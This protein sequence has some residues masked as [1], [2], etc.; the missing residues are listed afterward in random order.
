LVY[1]KIIKGNIGKILPY[2]ILRQK[3]IEKMNKKV[4]IIYLSYLKWDI[5]IRKQIVTLKKEGYDIAKVGIIDSVSVI[6]GVDSLP[7]SFSWSRMLSLLEM[8]CKGLQLVV[9]RIFECVYERIYRN[10]YFEQI[11][12]VLSDKKFDLYI[13]NDLNSLPPAIELKK[14]NGGKVL[15]DAHE[16]SPL[17]FANRWYWNFLIFPYRDYLCKKYLPQADY[18]ITVCDSLADKYHKEYGVKSEVIR[19]IP[20]YC[21][22]DFKKTNPS[23]IRMVHHGVTS[24]ARRLENMIYLMRFLDSKFTLDFMLLNV[25]KSYIKKLKGLAKNV[26]P[27]RIRF[28]DTVPPHDIIKTLKNY[29]IGIYLLG[30]YN[31][32]LKYALPNKFFEFMMAGLCVVAGTSPEMGKIINQYNFGIF[33]DKIDYRETAKV[34]NQLSKEEIDQMKMNSLSAAKELNGELEMKK[35]SEIVTNLLEKK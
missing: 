35:F 22:V 32:N 30:A 16:Y 1:N 19:N 2:Y 18:M 25:D 5:R 27:D 21:R 8:V 24:S 7:L 28:K 29:D 13:A 31:F 34:I 3:T 20:F 10:K 14:K 26:A 11:F 15:F 23:G 33:V 6:E 17:Q 9:G 4:C 12:Q